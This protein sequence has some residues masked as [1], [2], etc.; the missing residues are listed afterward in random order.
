MRLIGVIAQ[1]DIQ[2]K[3]VLQVSINDSDATLR[4]FDRITAL[5]SALIM[6]NFLLF[7]N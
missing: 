2:E 6:Q 5:Q 7:L 4:G 3:I 1:L